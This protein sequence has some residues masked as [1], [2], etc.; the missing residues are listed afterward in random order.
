MAENR[1]ADDF[2]YIAQRQRELYGER[3][4]RGQSGDGPVSDLALSRKDAGPSAELQD[5]ARQLRVSP[6]PGEDPDA[7]WRRVDKLS[8]PTVS[9]DGR[10]MGPAYR[11]A[12]TGHIVR[13]PIEALDDDSSSG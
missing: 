6:N 4:D 5:F 13:K 12:K 2:A 9:A 1:I 11:S 10:N 7:F 8:K 3:M